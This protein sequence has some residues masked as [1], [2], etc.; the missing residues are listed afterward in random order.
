[1]NRHIHIFTYLFLV[2]QP[3]VCIDTACVI[4]SIVKTVTNQDGNIP[5]TD[6]K[7]A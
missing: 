7:R 1:M 4:M 6:I 2:R 3:A 5:K